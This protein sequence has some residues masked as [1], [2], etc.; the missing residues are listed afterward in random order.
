MAA[1]YNGIAV[2]IGAVAAAVPLIGGFVLQC[3]TYRKQGQLQLQQ[4][5]N[6]VDGTR[7]EG[8]LDAVAVRVNGVTDQAISLATRAGNAEGKNEILTLTP[9]AKSITG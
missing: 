4:H 8:K 6:A 9:I 1:D 3:L 2:I 7:R 5:Q